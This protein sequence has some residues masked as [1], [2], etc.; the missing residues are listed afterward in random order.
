MSVGVQVNMSTYS[1]RREMSRERVS[2]FRLDPMVATFFGSPGISSISSVPTPGSTAWS[3]QLSPNFSNSIFSIA[4]Q[5]PLFSGV[6]LCGSPCFSS[7]TYSCLAMRWSLETV[8][9]PPVRREFDF[10]MGNQGDRFDAV[11]VGR[12]RMALY[13]D[14]TFTT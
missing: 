5:A 6:A 14:E 8:P 2:G 10:Q 4:L 7:S 3:V 11:K 9:I 13:E 1:L 12:P